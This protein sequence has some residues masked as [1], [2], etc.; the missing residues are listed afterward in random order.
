[1][2]QLEIDFSEPP[3]KRAPLKPEIE[4]LMLVAAFG[5]ARKAI[6]EKQ[7]LLTLAIL[8]HKRR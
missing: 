2:K 5:V 1:M 6:E 3:K 4:F 7:A 8:N